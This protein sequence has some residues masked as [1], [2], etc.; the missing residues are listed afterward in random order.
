MGSQGAPGGG[1][2]SPAAPHAAV[3]AASCPPGP[4]SLRTPAGKQSPP[5]GAGAPAPCGWGCRGAAQH[6]PSLA[7]SGLG[8]PHLVQAHTLTLLHT[9][10]HMYAHAHLCAH[11]CL[12]VL[13]HVCV[14]THTC[15]HSFIGTHTAVYG[16]ALLCLH[17]HT[18]T[19]RHLQGHRDTRDKLGAGPPG[20]PPPGT[21]AAPR[22]PTQAHT[23]PR[24]RPCDFDPA[25]YGHEGR[26]R[27]W[28]P[29]GSERPAAPQ[30]PHLV[31]R[32]G[33]S[34]SRGLWGSSYS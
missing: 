24:S 20:A 34:G 33:H 19:L 26:A 22:T 17:S 21:T 30:Q 18:R 10:A 5:Q 2:H 6:T 32:R 23:G 8:P 13:T 3:W 15:A 27:A 11:S 25:T 16:H 29:A 31:S 4:H 1:A 9:H 12:H 7:C 14:L 28:R